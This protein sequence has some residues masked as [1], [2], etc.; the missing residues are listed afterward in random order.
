M[1]R[2]GAEGIQNRD[3]RKQSHTIYY[4]LEQN[5][6]GETDNTPLNGSLLPAVKITG[7]VKKLI[8]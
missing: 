5:F 2:G 8:H 3:S 7:K 1:M 6:M 4:R